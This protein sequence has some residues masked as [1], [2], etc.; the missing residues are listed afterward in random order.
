M[1]KYAPQF[2]KDFF[3]LKKHRYENINIGGLK[4]G[5][6]LTHIANIF[7]PYIDRGNYATL[8]VGLSDEMPIDALM[9]IPRYC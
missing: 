3:E 8:Q 5:I 2:F 9:W 6:W 4:E 7:I 1:H